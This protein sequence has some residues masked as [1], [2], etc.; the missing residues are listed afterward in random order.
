MVNKYFF[1][2]FLFSI[3][4]GCST[5]NQEKVIT[6]FDLTKYLSQDSIK[7]YQI[8]DLV[9]GDTYKVFINNLEF[10]VRVIGV[11]TPE[12]SNNF[13]T[14]AD[15][16]RDGRDVQEIIKMGKLATNFVHKYLNEG[17]SVKL[18]LDVQHFDRYDRILA[19]V[20]LMDGRM[21]N[22]ILAREGYAQVMTIPP[23]VKYQELFLEAQREARN[24]KRGFWADS[25]A[26][27]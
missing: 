5:S 13:K 2:C 8:T 23:N 11:D 7:I 27:N 3:L 20:Y 10:K 26:S 19:Y 17:D 24:N 15:S 21:I 22:E 16:K 18:E 14:R 6:A 25:L 4:W 1:I 9:D 12:A